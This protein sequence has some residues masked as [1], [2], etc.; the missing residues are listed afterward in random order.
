MGVADTQLFAKTG[1]GGVSQLTGNFAATQGYAWVGGILI[2]WGVEPIPNSPVNQNH[3]TSSVTFKDRGGT[4]STIPFPNNCFVVVATLEVT[5]SGNL[6]RD[7]NISIR[8]FT[9]TAFTWVF[10]G[11]GTGTGQFQNFTWIAIGN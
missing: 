1:L 7:A 4:P 10:N 11:G 8:S 6:V 3:K 2:Q 5:S 9:K